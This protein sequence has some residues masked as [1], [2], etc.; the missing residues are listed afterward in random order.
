MKDLPPPF[1]FEDGG[2]KNEINRGCTNAA[3]K[4]CKTQRIVAK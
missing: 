4:H 2:L 1:I 3:I